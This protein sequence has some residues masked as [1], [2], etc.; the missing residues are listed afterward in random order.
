MA[1]ED[2]KLH[3]DSDWKAQAQAEKEKLRLRE[4]ARKQEEAKKQKPAVP[5]AAG[6]PQP[7]A[8]TSTAAPDTDDASDMPEATF[9]TLVNLLASQAL[10]YLGAMPEPRSGQRIV[11]LETARQ[12]IDLLAM[13][14][15]KTQGNLTQEE[16][17][18]LAGLLYQLRSRY[19]A[20]SAAMRQ[21][22]QG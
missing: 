1:D 9:D 19:I 14:E 22:D 2:H 11:S 5:P 7:Q 8:A 15:E 18:Q 17:D 20:V 3:I 13:L 4:E 16:A 6:Q 21:K 12:Q 10:L